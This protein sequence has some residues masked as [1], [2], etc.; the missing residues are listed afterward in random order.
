MAI[1]IRNTVHDG[2]PTSLRCDNGIIVELGTDVVPREGDEILD[3]DGLALVPGMVN[4]H[5]H[6]AMTLFRSFGDDL[7]L[8]RWLQE[9][10]WPAEAKLTADDVYW[11]T[12]LAAIEMLRSGTVEFCDMYW[13]GPAVAR[14]AADSGI[15]AIVASVFFDGGDAEAGTAQRTKVL[16]DL[17]AIAEAGAL[18]RPALGPHAIYTVSA[19]SL[20]WLAEVSEDR[21]VPLHIH[22]SETE[23]EV[24]DCVEAHGLRPALWVDELGVLSPRAILAHGSYLDPEELELVSARDATVVTNPVSNMKLANGRSLPYV[25]AARRG[26]AIGL[27]TDGASSNNALDLLAELKVFALLQKHEH[28]DP[29]VLPAAEALAVARGEQSPLLGARRIELGQPADLL[30]VDV[31]GPELTPGD[32]D[33]NLVYAATGAQVD[34]VVVG[35]EVAMRHR[36]VPGTDEVLAEVRARAERLR[37]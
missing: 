24:T 33:A 16:E 15:K 29:S 35:G 25:E 30:L 20:A 31:D 23:G 13:H 7:P 12:R 11:G 9:L 28:R 10:I 37:S 26:V 36:V 1:T 21:Q 22:L 4:G 32:L 8:M 17:D 6:A 2:R 27:G 18:V 34:T 3:A 14:A 19:E 5:T